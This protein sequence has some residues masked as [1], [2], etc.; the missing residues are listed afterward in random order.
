MPAEQKVTKDR[1]IAYFEKIRSQ[2]PRD[3]HP[4][5]IKGEIE[6]HRPKWLRGRDARLFDE[7][8]RDYASDLLGVYQLNHPEK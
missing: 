4:W 3:A 8:L 6:K 7:T 5:T 2:Q 1:C